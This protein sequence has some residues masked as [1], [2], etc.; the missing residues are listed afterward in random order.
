MYLPIYERHVPIPNL[1]SR[2][3]RT[4]VP[5][6]YTLRFTQHQLNDD[7]MLQLDTMITDTQ[8]SLLQNIL[9]VLLKTEF[10]KSSFHT[11]DWL[12]PID[13]QKLR[14]LREILQL[15]LQ[16][17]PSHICRKMVNQADLPE[18]NCPLHYS[19]NLPSQAA[20]KLL[21]YYGAEESL[22]SQNK[23]GFEPIKYVKTKFLETLLDRK[24]EF[25]GTKKPFLPMLL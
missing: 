6:S 20:T 14:N 22:F 23:H 19:V 12:N 2:D 25:E 13:W 17:L 5:N 15:I 4:Y 1:N 8:N 16:K 11:D 10:S 18:K 21:L 7:F 3:L 24:I 9:H